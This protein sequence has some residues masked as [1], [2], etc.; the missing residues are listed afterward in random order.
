MNTGDLNRLAALIKQER[1]D[2]LARWRQ[3]VRR[4]PG[5]QDLD[6]PTLTDHIPALL[7]ELSEALRLHDEARPMEVRLEDNPQAH[8][9]QRLR[10]GFDLTEVVSEYN[11]LR[12]CL[13]DLAE[14]HGLSLVGQAGHIIN[15]VLDEAIGLA[16][17]AYA[18][19]K[20]EELQQRRE[21]HL[22]FV[23][24]DLRTPLAAIAMAA[25][26]LEKKLS[27]AIA[28]DE[29][30]MLLKTLLR[31]ARR[32]EELVKQVVQEA[33]RLD[34]DVNAA[35]P[36]KLERRELDLW[37]LVQR[38]IDDLSPLADAAGARLINAV[39]ADCAVYADASLLTQVFQN[40]LANAIN[41]TPHGEITV[42]AKEVGA[43]G[44]GGKVECWVQ[45][46]G[47]GIPAER[48]GNVFDKLETDRA[49]QSGMGLGLAIVK[50]F[51]EAHGGTVSVEST[52][53]AGTTFR[54]TLPAQE[55]IAA[56]G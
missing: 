26:A 2:L 20:A 28:D 9:V 37:P 12:D 1:E 3:A 43:N 52:P 14:R 24:H 27:G 47:A 56:A 50:Q 42:G 54:F 4:L 38:L 46:T 7:E 41:Y 44:T 19:E 23:V 32:L 45:D 49:E 15:R 35:S 30:A 16:V 48:L 39:P 29:F 18:E 53:G 25:R 6:Q 34:T 8:G 31:N 10:V 40:L 11:M 5:A 13:Q 17:S 22:A 55:S 51:V 21:E 36:L 33:T